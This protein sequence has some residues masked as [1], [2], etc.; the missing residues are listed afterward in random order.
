M[1]LKAS[2]TRLIEDA[3]A[4]PE[5]HGYVLDFSNRTF[6]ELFEDEF[7]IDIDDARYRKFGASKRYRLL[8]FID[9]HDAYTVGKV[10]RR[11]WAHREELIED[12]DRN[13]PDDPPGLAAK[14]MSML[15]AVEREADLPSGDAFFGFAA[16]ETLDELIADL[17]RDLAAGKPAA[18]LDHLHTYVVKKLRFLL[19]QRGQ[20]A[21]RDEPL[22]SL[23]ARYRR[24][25]V[26]E[27]DLHPMTD[28]AMKLAI[29]MM[30]AFNNVRNDRSLAHD[31]ELLPKDEARL[32][33][34]AV[35]AMLRFIRSAEA[36]QFE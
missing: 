18:A 14:F 35:A 10:L 21:K 29:A 28:Q 15:D 11:L 1:R 27:R 34:D 5:G 8:G 13:G 3:F 22:H 20:E 6:A 2:Q 36:G 26:S 7:G 16:D 4:W 12:A 31:N 17:D 32:A 24:G 33:F 25:L 9:E 23:F 30:E 19:S